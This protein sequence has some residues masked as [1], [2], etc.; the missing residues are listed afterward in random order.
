MTAEAR[1][2]LLITVAAASI[3]NSGCHIAGSHQ[4]NAWF[5]GCLAANIK[6]SSLR[7]T[8]ELAPPSAFPKVLSQ[9]SAPA[10]SQ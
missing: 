6:Q 9:L 4:R 10:P 8:L 7:A 1:S 3:Y 5:R 2:A